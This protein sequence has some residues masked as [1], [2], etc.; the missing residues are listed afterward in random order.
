MTARLAPIDIT[1]KDE[2][3][4]APDITFEAP[5]ANFWRKLQ[6]EADPSI[7]TKAQV[8]KAAVL[9]VNEQALD[10]ANESF[11]NFK[12]RHVVPGSQTLRHPLPAVL[13]EAALRYGV[14]IAY[15]KSLPTTVEAASIRDAKMAFQM[16]MG[17]MLQYKDIRWTAVWGRDT[18]FPNIHVIETA[19]KA[20]ETRKT[21][22]CRYMHCRNWDMCTFAHTFDELE[23]NEC[24]YDPKC[25][26]PDC[27]YKHANETKEEYCRRLR[28]R[29]PRPVRREL[30]Y[31]TPS[32]EEMVCTSICS[33]VF[34]G[35]PCRRKRNGRC[36][37]A[38]TLEEFKP[39]VCGH[40]DQC[41]KKQWCRF[42]HPGEDKVALCT[43]LGFTAFLTSR[44]I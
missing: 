1:F 37:F 4:D 11:D 40:G 27:E 44:T 25:R 32:K 43:R 15:V 2:D 16:A 18:D 34:E 24:S 8:E 6:I 3:D 28:L 23:P 19:G 26:K 31:D 21:R 22:M 38:H 33:S 20:K 39:V 10:L 9:R 35:I 13:A 42:L 17:A 5:K 12:R 41:Y 36:T 7:P 14:Y 29:E 30:V